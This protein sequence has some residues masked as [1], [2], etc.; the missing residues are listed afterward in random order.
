MSQVILINGKKRHGKDFIASLLKNSLEA[1]GKSVEIISFADP[2]KQIIATMFGIT[3]EEL[4]EY[5]NDTMTYSLQ[6]VDLYDGTTEYVTNFRTLLQRFGNEAMKPM[7]GDLVWR[8]LLYSKTVCSEADYILVPDFRFYC[9]KIEEAITINVFNNSI[10]SSDKHT[11]ETELE[12]YEFDY[13][14]NNTDYGFRQEH[15]EYFVKT[16]LKVT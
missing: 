3:E 7:F 11:S 8:N 10:P 13:Y 16:H 1:K 2:M 14:I 6:V 15:A 9:E 5:K 4:D 12:N